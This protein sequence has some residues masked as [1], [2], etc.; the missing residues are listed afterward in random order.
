MNSKG[1]FIICGLIIPWLLIAGC[2]VPFIELGRPKG[3]EI[4]AVEKNQTPQDSSQTGF[5]TIRGSVKDLETCEGIPGASIMSE[6]T[7][8]GTASSFSGDFLI[9]NVPPG[10]YTI[11]VKTIGYNP[12]I[13]EDLIVRADEII[14][15][16]IVMQSS[17][18][19]YDLGDYL[20][21]PLIKR[22][23]TSNQKTID[24]DDIEHMP[25]STV[26]DIL[27]KTQGFVR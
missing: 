11:I 14:E 15:M 27:K 4:K 26:D 5:S 9:K 24:E 13:V 23:Q 12:V 19:F 17:G 25:A 10:R 1:I 3:I 21:P 6:D 20:L 7:L 8:F 16:E 2:S 22:Y 18:V